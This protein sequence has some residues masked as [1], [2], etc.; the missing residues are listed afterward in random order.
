MGGQRIP[1]VDIAENEYFLYGNGASAK[2]PNQMR[3]K[4]M[5]RKAAKWKDGDEMRSPRRCPKT[6]A[7]DC[8]GENTSDVA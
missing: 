5:G 7:W 6:S 3:T 4:G 8:P 1:S 2:F